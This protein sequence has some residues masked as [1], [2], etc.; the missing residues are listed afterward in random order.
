MTSEIRLSRQNRGD[1]VDELGEE[2]MELAVGP[3]R[4]GT[5]ARP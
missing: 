2:R 3:E 1:L 4:G 5:G